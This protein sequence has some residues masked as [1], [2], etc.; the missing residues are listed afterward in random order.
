[1]LLPL[2]IRP[3]SP[4]MRDLRTLVGLVYKDA[5]MSDTSGLEMNGL[6]E[7]MEAFCRTTHSD[8]LQQHGIASWPT[9]V[10][11]IQKEPI[12]DHPQQYEIHM[13][14][15]V[16]GSNSSSIEAVTTNPEKDLRSQL[17]ALL[18]DNYAMH[19]KMKTNG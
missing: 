3:S 12:P 19:E 13:R 6:S 9:S 18:D 4:G 7:E 16:Q 17:G 10:T 11:V 14:C 15:G 1:L 8:F 2:V 5:L